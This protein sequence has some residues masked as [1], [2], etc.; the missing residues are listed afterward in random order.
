MEYQLKING[1]DLSADLTPGKDNTARVT[2]GDTE[3]EMAFERISET[4]LQ[5]RVNGRQINAWVKE[6]P[7][8]KTVVLNGRHFTIMDPMVQKQA[9][10]TGN[11]PEL[12]T[13]TLVTPPMPAIVI[14][15]PVNLGDTV[16]KGDAVVVVSA[17]KMETPLAAPHGGTVTRIGVAQGDKVMPGDI[18]VDIEKEE[19]P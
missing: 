11:T 15:V 4:G 1:E 16:A 9:G 13:P 10:S 7:N 3:Y 18:L 8:G 12:D 6:G 17:M 19:T 5:L 2:L 14:Q